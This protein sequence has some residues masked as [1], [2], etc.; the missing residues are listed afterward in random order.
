[1]AAEK[2]D[3]SELIIGRN[4]ITEAL[5]SGRELNQLFVARGER[6]GSLGHIVSL[7]KER[8]IPVKEVDIKKLDYLSNGGAHQGV[9][10]FCAAHAYAA[11]ED[12]FALAQ[13]RGEAPFIILCDEIEDPHN[14]GAII[15][16]ADAVGAHGVVVPKRRS[17]AL[18][19]VVAKASAGAIEY[20][21]V[22]RVTNL[23]AA[24][25]KMKEK[26]MWIY[27]SDMDGEDYRKVN[28]SG[29]VGLVIGSEGR[30]VSRLVRQKC[31]VV[32]S[33]PMKGKINSLNASVAAA[34]LMY[35]AADGR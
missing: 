4:P 28:F 13:E 11:L 8:G 15:R 23:A 14:L 20:V 27:C 9:A 30:G 18:T 24:I 33:L 12:I 35:A 32:V 7:A 25:D 3:N 26:N 1:M 5:K 16:T 2:S 6:S 22:A 17:A 21:K 10:A 34:V 29:G 19:G 31:D